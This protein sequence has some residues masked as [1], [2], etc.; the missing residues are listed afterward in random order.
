MTQ[1]P[2]VILVGAGYVGTALMRELSRRGRE[3]QA[4]VS[5]KASAERMAD[6]GLSYQRVDLDADHR[7]I[8]FPDRCGVVYLV[9]PERTTDRDER[10]SRF[11]DQLPTA[12]SALV[13]V[14]TTGIYGDQQ[15][16]LVDET[17]APAPHS[18]RARRR[19]DA[20][21]QV[22]AICEEHRIT[23]RI[24]RVPG[25]YGPGRLPLQSLK[26]ARPVIRV[27][28]ANPG[29]R[30]HRDDLARALADVFEQ[31]EHA[32]RDTDEH[33]RGDVYNLGDNNYMSSSQFAMEVARLAGLPEP[34]QISRAD[35]KATA[36]SVRW[37]FLVESRRLDSRKVTGVLS[38]PLRYTNPLLGIQASLDAPDDPAA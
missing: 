12:V 22:S 29:N 35:M 34:P 14:S 9:P 5:S 26:D 30:I 21:Q 27:S 37:S 6:A 15:G 16:K 3:C 31:A 13:Y 4:V 23:W 28:E 18:A 7:S 32:S 20:E 25:I 33:I 36:S 38:E 1:K 19:V 10:L 24:A 11:L 17:V 2:A 8:V